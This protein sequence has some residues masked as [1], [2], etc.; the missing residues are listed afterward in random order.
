MASIKDALWTAPLGGA[1]APVIGAAV[2]ELRDKIMNIG[3]DETKAA[4]P[5][6]EKKKKEKESFSPN[7]PAQV[8]QPTYKKGGKVSSASKRADGC[9]I[10][11]KT[12][13]RVV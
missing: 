13:G 6:E 1:V 11:G 9:A 10:R 12:K 3:A 7:Q 5:E 4:T 8:Y 2:P